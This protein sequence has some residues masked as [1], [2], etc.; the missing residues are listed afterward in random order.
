MKRI[1]AN[2]T[3]FQVCTELRR[4]ANELFALVEIEP[5]NYT[6]GQM[7]D[8]KSPHNKYCKLWRIAGNGD[9]YSANVDIFNEKREINVDGFSMSFPANQVFALLNQFE[10]FAKSGKSTFRRVDA[11]GIAPDDNDFKAKIITPAESES[12]YKIK[13][14]TL[15]P[16]K[17]DGVYISDP[18]RPGKSCLIFESDGVYFQALDDLHLRNID[19]D[20]FL[21]LTKKTFDNRLNTL[22]RNSENSKFAAA[23]LRAIEVAAK[24][25]SNPAKAK[26]MPKSEPVKPTEPARNGDMVSGLTAIFASWGIK[27]AAPNQAVT[28]ESCPAKVESAAP[29]ESPVTT[30]NKAPEATLAATTANSSTEPNQAVTTPQNQPQQTPPESATNQAGNPPGEPLPNQSGNQSPN[31]AKIKPR[32]GLFNRIWSTYQVAAVIA[33]NRFKSA[34]FGTFA[35]IN[36]APRPVDTPGENHRPRAGPRAGPPPS[37]SPLAYIAPESYAPRVYIRHVTRQKSRVYRA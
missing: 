12:G 17:L 33:L 10:S 6:A 2:N 35:P 28:P 1:K 11:S 26:T 29:P 13:S 27:P 19:T 24:K 3:D 9:D 14:N 25:Q 32:N 4:I 18:T 36:A 20:S 34:N 16:W 21:E 22:N 23:V 5:G 7:A 8:N 30:E 31:Q 37:A 15:R